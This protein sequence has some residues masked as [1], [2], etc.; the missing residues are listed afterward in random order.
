MSEIEI[1]GPKGLP[2]T[3]NLFA[4]R[5]NPL[6]FLR[7]AA[8]EYGDIV[9]LRFG[10]RHLYLISNPDYIKEVLVTKQAHFKKGKGLQVAKAVVGEGILTSE[11]KFHM[12]Q[13]RLMQPSFRQDH[14]V[15]YGDTMVEYGE[16]LISKWKDGEERL[17]SKDM[18]ELTLSIITKTMFGTSIN[19]NLNDIEHAIDVGLKYVSR[20]ASSFIDIPESIPTKSNRE[21]KEAAETLDKVIFSIIEERRKS[22][23]ENRG[24]LLSML[25]AA[26]DEDDGTGMTD[27]QV[28][29]EVMTI[30]IAGHE[31]TANTLSWTLYLLAQHPEAEQKLWSEIEQ[32]LGGRKVT[33]H[34]L[35]KLKY[36]E[37]IIWETLRLYPAAWAINRE[38]TDEIEIGGHTFKPGE[39]IMMSQYVMHRNPKY[40]DNPDAF[41]P[42]RFAGNLL[43]EI[44][45]FAFFPFGGGPRVCIGNHFAIME[46]TLILVTISQ[47]FQLRLADP[48]NPV[49]PEPVVTLRPKNGLRMIVK[50]R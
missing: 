3:G 6:E 11:G 49:E 44:P 41:I 17:I 31:T 35:P 30:F 1:L 48:H 21:F 10:P 25:L 8:E 40:F 27:H 2:I 29:D 23:D 13:R 43:K 45:Q 47:K 39:S 28:R 18:M 42:E 24:D 5:K 46:A 4:F 38:V 16:K 15:S 22:E 14:I 20:R 37:N 36:A 32:V 19:K 9:H 7:R 34:D 50:K 12:R 26:R 33:V